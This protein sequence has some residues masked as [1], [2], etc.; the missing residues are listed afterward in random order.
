MVSKV[1]WLLFLSLL[2]S[3]FSF[4]QNPQASAQG[5]NS[6]ALKSL[7]WGLKLSYYSPKTD[8]VSNVFNALEDTA[9]LARGPQFSIYYLAG[10]N[11]RYSLNL[12]NDIGIEGEMSLAQTKLKN[13][14]SVER[15]YTIGAQYYYHLQPRRPG[16]YGVDVGGGVAWLVANFERNYDNSRIALLKKSVRLNGAVEWWAAISQH[17]YLELEARYLFVPNI[18]VDYPQTTIKMSSAIVSVGMSMDF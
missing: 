4:A 14:T 5:A 18:K 15:V 16:A 6:S 9:G 17:V 11:L 7:S 12:R 10:V 2:S 1:T 8:N 13:V 3:Q